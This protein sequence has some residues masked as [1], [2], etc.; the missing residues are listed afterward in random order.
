MTCSTTLCYASFMRIVCQQCHYFPWLGYFELLQA[1]K[2][3]FLDSVQWTKQGRH[4]RTKIYANGEPQWLSIP[5]QSA[6]HRQKSLKDMQVDSSQ[7]W[8][9]HHWDLLENAYKK[10]PQFESQLKPLLK[11]FLEKMQAEKFLQNIS[12]QSL[13]LF[14]EA[15]GFQPEL[16]WASELPEAGESTE[17]LVSLCQALGGNEYFSSLGS[18]RY[19][20]ISLFRAAGIQVR[21]QHFRKFFPGDIH[22]PADLSILDWVAYLPLS[23]IKEK[24]LPQ[25]FARSELELPLHIEDGAAPLAPE[26]FPQNRDGA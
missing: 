6:G 16:F 26:N 21:W 9:K 7:H 17:R 11:P 12:E 22:R 2:F 24:F 5:V 1:D 13:W 19:L 20:D 4:H 23:E 14:Q 10:A 18:T 25:S 3:V 8:G 15:L